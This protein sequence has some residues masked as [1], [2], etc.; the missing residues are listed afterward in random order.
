MGRRP[1]DSRPLRRSPFVLR[2]RQRRA[3]LRGCGGRPGRGGQQGT[4]DGDPPTGGAAERVDRPTTPRPSP[5]AFWIST[6][7]NFTPA[8]TSS[9]GYEPSP[10]CRS[11]YGGTTSPSARAATERL[12]LTAP[13]PRAVGA[14]RRRPPI[15][16]D[17]RQRRRLR[18]DC[19]RLKSS[20]Q[21]HSA[22]LPG[23]ERRHD[24][25]SA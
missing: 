24:N 23:K 17:N 8:A 2:R 9:V 16:D 1:G 22:Y 20:P 11:K 21:P 6:L 19:Y 14:P 7:S 15:S 5:V 13:F 10:A 12:P 18:S 25:T 3:A 4:A